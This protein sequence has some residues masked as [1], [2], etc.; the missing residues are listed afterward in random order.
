M[1]KTQ[2]KIPGMFFV[3]NSSSNLYYLKMLNDDQTFL[4]ISPGDSFYVPVPVGEF[5]LSKSESYNEYDILFGGIV[6]VWGG[7]TACYI[8]NI[9]GEMEFDIRNTD[10]DVRCNILIDEE[11]RSFGAIVTPKE[12][13]RVTA[14]RIPAIR[15]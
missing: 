12:Q 2:P 1:K 13:G 5:Y 11:Y 9:P 3:K 14:K 8:A 4:E 10:L 7:D 15:A 6:F